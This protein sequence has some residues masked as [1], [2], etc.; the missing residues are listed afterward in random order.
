[1]AKKTVTYTATAT[2]RNGQRV[3][4]EGQCTIDD[5]WTSPSDAR[6]VAVSDIQRHGLR[7]PSVDDATTTDK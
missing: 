2:D 5:R 1:M 3:H 7:R 6:N 4:V